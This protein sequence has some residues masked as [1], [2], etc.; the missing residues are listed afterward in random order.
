M[1]F[2]CTQ[3]L[4]YAWVILEEDEGVYFIHMNKIDFASA[5]LILWQ[6]YRQS[7]KVRKKNCK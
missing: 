5:R 6:L 2:W 4:Q 7:N 1:H 3:S